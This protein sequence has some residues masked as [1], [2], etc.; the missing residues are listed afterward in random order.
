MEKKYLLHKRQK[1]NL[2]PILFLGQTIKIQLVVADNIAKYYVIDI[3][4]RRI[5]T[6]DKK[7][8]SSSFNSEIK[9]YKDKILCYRFTEYVLHC[10][11]IN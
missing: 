1:K 6:V 4:Y 11:S 9:I 3:Q 10:Y 7:T 2:R 5:V 8:H